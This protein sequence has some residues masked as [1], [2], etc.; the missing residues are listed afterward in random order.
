MIKFTEEQRKILNISKNEY[1]VLRSL[2]KPKFI[3][4]ISE[5]TKIPRATL[6]PVIKLLFERG[7]ITCEQRGKRFQYLSISSDYF[8]NTLFKISIDI[9]PKPLNSPAKTFS[10]TKL[11]PQDKISDIQADFEDKIDNE[12]L[13]I[14]QLTGLVPEQTSST[15][16]I[17]PSFG[18]LFK[19]FFRK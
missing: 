18:K 7:L 10:A 6:Y 2:N 9:G 16:D 14:E 13:V 1:I 3:L 12:P 4:T 5:D 11:K 8:A 17:K 19:S 15:K